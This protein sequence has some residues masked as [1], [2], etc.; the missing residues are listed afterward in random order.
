ME[1]LLLCLSAAEAWQAAAGPAHRA[2]V[3]IGVSCR[4][5]RLRQCWA[6]A[7]HGGGLALPSK[8]VVP[9]APKRLEGSSSDSAVR[10]HREV[11][12]R[13]EMQQTSKQSG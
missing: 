13:V 6:V 4:Q 7:G 5:V 1:R 9:L 2:G 11:A 12:R 8:A 10:T 3:S